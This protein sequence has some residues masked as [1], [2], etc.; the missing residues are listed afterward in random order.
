MSLTHFLRKSN[1]FM[2]KEVLLKYGIAGMCNH[3]DIPEKQAEVKTSGYAKAYEKFESIKD[4]PSAPSQTF[5]S[6]LRNSKFIDV[7][8]LLSFSA[9]IDAPSA[10]FYKR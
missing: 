2:K 10:N 6:L 9:L 5:A 1:V 8:K 7:S 4:T 3:S